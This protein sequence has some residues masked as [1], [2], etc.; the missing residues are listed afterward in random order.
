MTWVLYF[1]LLICGAIGIALLIVT[2]PGLWL[3]AAGA[4]AYAILTRLHYLGLRSLLILFLMALT[5]E[6]LE[7]A[8]MGREAGRAGGRRGT[9]LGA[10]IG[11]IVGATAGSF[12]PIPIVGTILGLCVGCF[13]G[14]AIVEWMG[15][16]ATRK[17]I[18]V[19][20]GAAKGRAYGLGTK[21]IIGV[22]M[23]LVILVMA[24]P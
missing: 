10:F 14:A 4:A 11:G 23:L 22:A 20:I 13:F 18:E 21:F 15:G 17:S 19:G 8:L 5:G 24:F 3:I 12:I 7:V 6:V 1:L 2:M 16:G 9:G